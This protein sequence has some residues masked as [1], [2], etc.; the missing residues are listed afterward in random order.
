M[1]EQNTTLVTWPCPPQGD[2]DDFI[3]AFEEPFSA[4]ER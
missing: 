4:S 3:F 2:V 1:E